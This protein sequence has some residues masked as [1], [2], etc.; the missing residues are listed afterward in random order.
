MK[1]NVGCGFDY[2]DNF[3]NIDGIDAIPKVDMVI[4]LNKHSLLEFFEENSSEHIV[5]NDFI[6]HHFHW[7]AVAIMYDF[8]KLL[9]PK[10]MLEMRLPDFGRITSPFHWYN[11]ILS[12]RKKL[13]LLF[14]GQDIPQGEKDV[15]LRRNFPQFFCHKYAYTPK[16]IKSELISIGFMDVKTKSKGTN[17]LVF[18]K[19][20]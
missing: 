9:K 5:A 3:V 12:P 10:G 17:F 13:T 16:T 1:L 18:A 7:E 6:E 2:R 11:L 4:D 8:Y 14:G 20:P 19:K 15:S